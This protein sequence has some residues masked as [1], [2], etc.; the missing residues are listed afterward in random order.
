VALSRP[1]FDV[2]EKFELALEITLSLGQL[3]F[4]CCLDLLAYQLLAL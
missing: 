4:F 1:E 2:L 3:A